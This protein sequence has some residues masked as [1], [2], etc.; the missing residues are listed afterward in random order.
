MA[1]KFGRVRV[2][3]NANPNFGVAFMG[4]FALI[5]WFFVGEQLIVSLK[6]VVCVDNA[7]SI[8]YNSYKFLGLTTGTAGGGMIGILGIIAAAGII[9]QFV[10]ITWK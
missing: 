4:I 6:G 3:R 1:V 8:F 9:L 7:S 2:S 5:I 10:R